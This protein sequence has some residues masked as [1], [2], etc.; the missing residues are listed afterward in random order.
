MNHAHKKLCHFCTIDQHVIFG[1]FAMKK[2]AVTGGSG[3]AGR[4]V[5]NLLYL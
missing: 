2:I 4:V 1:R 3:G 5:F